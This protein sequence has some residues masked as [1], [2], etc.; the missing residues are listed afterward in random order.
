MA[1]MRFKPLRN[2]Q[3][4][5]RVKTGVAAALVGMLVL[6][7]MIVV[8][9]SYIF[10]RK[11]IS[12]EVVGLMETTLN[13]KTTA[14]ADWLADQEDDVWAIA[15]MYQ[16]G[17]QLQEGGLNGGYEIARQRFDDFLLGLRV[18]YG[19]RYLEYRIYDTLGTEIVI[20]ETPGEVRRDT[21]VLSAL[22]AVRTVIVNETVDTACAP[23]DLWLCAP[24][25]PGRPHWTGVLAARLNPA[26]IVDLFS[27]PTLAL[28]F[29]AY[30]VD[31]RRRSII[32]LH[33]VQ[34]AMASAEPLSEAASIALTGQTGI[35]RY[36]DYRGIDV[37]GAFTYLSSPGWGLVIEQDYLAAYDNLFLSSGRSGRFE[38][39]HC[40]GDSKL[41]SASSRVSRTSNAGTFRATH[42]RRQTVHGRGD[43][44]LRRARNKQSPDDD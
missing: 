13:Q 18:A 29:K 36:K 2:M 28:S 23:L 42:C 34:E 37:I 38:H 39:Y 4:Y 24:I 12:E 17:T 35:L 9:A 15:S 26:M 20:P 19:D 8:I 16:Y 32:P 25:G 11:V 21:M 14:L 27:D 31:E 43:G 1:D 44:G 33:N 10:A 5:A 30:L 40:P 41:G 7:T 3:A 6:P 22:S